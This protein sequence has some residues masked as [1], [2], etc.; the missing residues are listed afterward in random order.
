MSDIPFK[1]GGLGAERLF[2]VF[3]STGAFAF[4]SAVLSCG[5]TVF[6]FAIASRI[7][8]FSVVIYKKKQSQK[9]CKK[10]I[11]TNS[12]KLVEKHFEKKC[13][14]TAKG[15]MIWETDCFS[16]LARKA[17]P[18]IFLPNVVVKDKKSLLLP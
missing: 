12:N 3:F 7:E 17:Q 15:E 10:K 11:E 4:F 9:F 14:N 8:W 18:H 5:A 1:T 2:L 6:F 16:I 13:N